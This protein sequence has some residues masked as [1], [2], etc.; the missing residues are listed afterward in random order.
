MRYPSRF[1]RLLLASAC[2]MGAAIAHAQPATPPPAK[3]LSAADVV[4]AAPAASWVAIDPHDL[5]VMTLAP[6]ARGQPREVLIQL[7]PA[8]F[9]QGWVGNLR[10]LAAAHWWDGLSVYRVQDNWVAQWGDG[11]GEDKAKAKPL[12]EGLAKVDESQ[13]TID[14]GPVDIASYAGNRFGLFMAEAKGVK[15]HRLIANLLPEM[16]DAFLAGQGCPALPKAGP[17]LHGR[18]MRVTISIR[19]SGPSTATPPS[20]S[21]AISR[22][23]PAPGPN[24]TP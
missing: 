7:M 8:P 19:H 1:C 12:P 2:M 11:E 21:L 5:L 24:S 18:R 17:S 22:P 6:D 14:V 23:I 15:P 4:K 10:K 3:P 20:A 16:T 9:S 13:Y